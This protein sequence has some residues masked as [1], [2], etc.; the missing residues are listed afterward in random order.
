[1][2]VSFFSAIFRDDRLPGLSSVAGELPAYRSRMLVHRLDT[3]LKAHFTKP[4]EAGGSAG[5]EFLPEEFTS[6][7]TLS[8]SEGLSVTKVSWVK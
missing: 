7:G 2:L 8:V 4:G 3:W 6:V 1:M 5:W